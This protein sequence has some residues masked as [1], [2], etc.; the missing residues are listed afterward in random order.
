MQTE[1][2]DLLPLRYYLLLKNLG[3]AYEELL[4]LLS[5]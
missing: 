1:S 4:H 2:S 3:R 5:T